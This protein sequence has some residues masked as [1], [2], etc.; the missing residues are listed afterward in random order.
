MVP[1]GRET[2]RSLERGVGFG[3]GGVARRVDG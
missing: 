1:R 3:L 2:R